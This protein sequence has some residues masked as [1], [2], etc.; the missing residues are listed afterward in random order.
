[1]AVIS[2]GSAAIMSV[3]TSFGSDVV[4][5]FGAA[6]RLDSLIM[7]P[8]QALG[9]AVSSMAGQN[10]GVR[11]WGRVSRITRVALIYNL[12]IMIVIALVMV[13]FADQAVRLFIQD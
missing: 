7:L 9:I 3:V 11:N 10:I 2:A 13:V 5:G 6:Q 4:G 8:A 12:A 1:M